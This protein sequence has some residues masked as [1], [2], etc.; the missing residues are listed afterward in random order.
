MKI[1]NIIKFVL[2][3]LVLNKALFISSVSFSNENI[4]ENETMDY[5]INND[6]RNTEYNET[7]NDAG[8][9]FDFDWNGKDLV[10]IKRNK[11][12]YPIVRYSLFDNKNFE[13]SNTAVVKIN[14]QDLSKLSDNELIKLTY[15]R[16][17]NNYELDN[18][19]TISISSKPYK[20][21]N[22]K[23]E[24]FE[25]LSIQNIDTNI[26][27]LEMSFNSQF[28]NVRKDLIKT[29]KG[30]DLFS[31][32]LINICREAREKNNWPL[33]TVEFEEFRYDADVREGLK[34]KEVLANPVFQIT[35]DDDLLRTLRTEKGVGF[36]RQSFDFRSFPFDTQKLI[37]R[38]KTGVKNYSNRNFEDNKNIGT[39]TLISPEAGV[40]VNLENFIKPEVNKLKAWKIPNDGVSVKS[41]VLYS[42]EWNIYNQE[43]E[44]V[45]ENVLDIEIIIQ[46]NFEHY[47]WK[48][49]LPVFLILCVAWYV[50][51]IP[52][53]KYEARLN[54]SIIA[55]LALIAYNF[56]F[57]DDI[58][59]LEY[60]T[61]MDRFI[62]LSYIFCCIPVFLSI[63]FSKFISKNQI[64]VMKINKVIKI[65]GAAIYILLSVQIFYAG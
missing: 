38:I 22:F 34:N 12:N 40:F 57:Q 47:L 31:D 45:E 13:A 6:P 61:D 24:N 55:L 10:V 3:L 4:C 18:G 28:T 35:I 51:W 32:Q 56:V 46:R 21:N 20:F 33:E 14:N 5:I 1:K 64:K 48:I 17:E 2:F 37:I 42:N 36:F 49:M 50:L 39:L 27:I 41:K 53:E 16:G 26:G 58:P 54:T 44:A 29:L 9:H 23:L 65:W 63:A 52:T 8:I 60:L 7:R 59:K 25:I 19:K 43:I 15:L 30:T 62:L 11:K